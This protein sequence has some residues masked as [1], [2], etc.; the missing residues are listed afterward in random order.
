MKLALLALLLAALCA[1]TAAASPQQ[2]MADD[3]ETWISEVTGAQP[4]DR[5]VTHATKRELAD[6]PDC[7]G[8]A[9]PDRIVLDTAT[10]VGVRDASRWPS[11]WAPDPYPFHVLLHELLHRS[12][13][14]GPN[15]EALVDALAMD[16]APAASRAVVGTTLRP[17]APIYRDGVSWVRKQSAKAC[18]CRWN[19]RG[20]RLIRRSWW[21]ADDATRAAALR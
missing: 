21:A 5:P 12:A 3:L 11:V 20:A 4:L 18:G 10:W 15:E 19:E 2:Q 8:I 13:R 14:G 6:C 9:W 16:L 1:G 7:S 17:T